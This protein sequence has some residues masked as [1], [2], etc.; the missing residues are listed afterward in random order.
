[1]VG[2][3]GLDVQHRRFIYGVK[4]GDFENIIPTFQQFDGSYAYWIGACRAVAG[5]DTD[6]GQVL[7]A[8]G[9]Y[10]HNRAL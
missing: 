4:A 10:F 2:D 7:V 1:V 3:V 5:K 6:E 9:M 8:F